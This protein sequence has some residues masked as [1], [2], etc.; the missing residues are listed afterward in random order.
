MK[1]QSMF[2]NPNLVNPVAPEVTSPTA[3]TESKRQETKPNPIAKQLSNPKFKPQTIKDKKKEV[4]KGYKKHKKVDID[5][6]KILVK[7]I[8]GIWLANVLLN[9]EGKAYIG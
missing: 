9:P 4:N 3:L 6:L 8:T 2:I 7:E 5:E 1:L